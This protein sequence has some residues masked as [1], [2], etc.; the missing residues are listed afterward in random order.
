M[1]DALRTFQDIEVK[2]VASVAQP[3]EVAVASA[4]TCYSGRGVIYPAE[5]S[6]DESTGAP[7]S[8]RLINPR[9]GPC[10]HSPACALC[11][12][13]LRRFA[14]VHLELFAQPPVL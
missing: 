4:R 2:L 14:P 1:L 9:S 6:K 3:Y 7:R 13:D 8:D 10:D 11:F 5:V 12:C